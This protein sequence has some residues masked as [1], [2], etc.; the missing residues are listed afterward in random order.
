QFMRDLMAGGYCL[1]WENDIK[2][3]DGT[4][5]GFPKPTRKYNG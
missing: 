4:S 2:V 1:P 5:C 3:V